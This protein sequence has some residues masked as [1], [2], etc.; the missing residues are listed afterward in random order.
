[1]YNDSPTMSFDR[2]RINDRINIARIKSE[3]QIAAGEI[4]GELCNFI[5]ETRPKEV[6]AMI[7]KLESACPD[8]YKYILRLELINTDIYCEKCN[9]I[10]HVTGFNETATPYDIKYNETLIV[11]ANRKLDIAKDRMLEMYKSYKEQKTEIESFLSGALEEIKQAQEFSSNF[12]I[13]NT[14]KEKKQ[15]SQPSQPSQPSP[16]SMLSQLFNELN[17]TPSV[18]INTTAAPPKPAAQQRAPFDF[19]SYDDDGMY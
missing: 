3:A 16:Q 1:M 14:V 18:S 17:S 12:Q 11:N 7:S 13:E 9:T 15:L 6:A 19:L 2:E 5:R 8:L 4:K 10:K